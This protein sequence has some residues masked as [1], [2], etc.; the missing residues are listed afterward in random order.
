MLRFPAKRSGGGGGGGGGAAGDAAATAAEQAEEEDP[1]EEV[2]DLGSNL[3]IPDPTP[4]AHHPWSLI[5]CP[6]RTTLTRTRA[7]TCP[8]R[9][10]SRRCPWCRQLR[11]RR[12]HPVHMHMGTSASSRDGACVRIKARGPVRDATRRVE[13]R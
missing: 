12:R 3:T 11:R 1:D 9:R 8:A 2:T 4:L 5:V 6:G 10:P 7:R 13:K